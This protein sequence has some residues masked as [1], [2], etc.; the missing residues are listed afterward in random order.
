MRFEWDGQKAKENLS[1]H[2]VA[3]DEAKLV[4]LDLFAQDEFDSEHSTISETRFIRLG[5]V[6]PN[7]LLVVYTVKD[8]NT[9]TYRIISA[10]FFSC[11]RLPRT[12][13]TI[14]CG[15]VI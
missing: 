3:F 10:H 12:T 15:P 1:K 13:L 2:N 7:I 5:L 11:Q 9:N 8:E 6:F 14:C 4:F